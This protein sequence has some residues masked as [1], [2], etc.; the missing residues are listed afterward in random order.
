M[1]QFGYK[2][3]LAKDREADKAS[4]CGAKPWREV[5]SS[6]RSRNEIQ[7]E[8]SLKVCK[9]HYC[10]TFK[11]NRMESLKYSQQYLSIN[12][13]NVHRVPIQS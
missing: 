1:G 8:K 4:L 13:T 5:S 3:Q 10:L 9:H 12:S 11:N 7:A 6:Q 2:D